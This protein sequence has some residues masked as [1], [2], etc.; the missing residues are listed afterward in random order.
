[1]N[2]LLFQLVWKSETEIAYRQ[3]CRG[4]LNSSA[5]WTDLG[6]PENRSLKLSIV[7]IR[8]FSNS[9]GDLGLPGY[10][11]LELPIFGITDF[12]IVLLYELV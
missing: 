10:H 4:F 9:W 2:V 5:V 6:L 3:N 1:M 7:R 12:Q 11:G 8:A